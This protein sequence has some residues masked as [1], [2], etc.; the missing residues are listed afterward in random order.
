M[1]DVGHPNAQIRY[2][3]GR[4]HGSGHRE[5]VD[6]VLHEDFADDRQFTSGR[7]GRQLVMKGGDGAL[8]IDFTVRA[9]ADTFNDVIEWYVLSPLSVKE[10]PHLEQAVPGFTG[11]FARWLFDS[12]Y[13]PPE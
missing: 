12:T 6:A 3:V 4:I 13:S 1:G 9:F 10:L 8:R 5:E 7:L 11:A 2:R